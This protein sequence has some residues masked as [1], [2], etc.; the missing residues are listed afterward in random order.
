M[1][2]EAESKGTSV[3]EVVAC[4]SLAGVIGELMQ[5][6]EVVDVHTHLFRPAMET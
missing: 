3:D 6:A 4:D 2:S 1:A 5:D